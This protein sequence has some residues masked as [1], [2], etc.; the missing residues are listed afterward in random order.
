MLQNY[1]HAIWQHL[2]RHQ[3]YTLLNLAGLTTGLL[4]SLVLSL[5]VYHEQHYDAFHEKGEQIVRLDAHLQSA[6]GYDQH[7][8]RVPFDWINEVETAL[9]EV[10]KLVRFQ[11]YYPRKV[12]VGEQLY[13]ESQAFSTDPYVFEVFSFELLAGNP[14]TALSQPY[15]VVLTAERAQAYFGHLQV[16]GKEIEILNEQS[17]AMERYEVTGVMA[18]LP[19]Q[20]HLPMT[21][22]TSFA[23]AEARSGWAYCYALLGSGTE[24]QALRS[25]LPGF[26]SARNTDEQTT[27]TIGVMPLRAIH[28]ASDLAREI[29]PGGEGA[30]VQF[31]G[32]VALVILLVAG[33][34][35]AQLASARTL[36]RF[37]EVG[38]RRVLGSGSL[39]LMLF[40]WLEALLL[41]A[42]ALVLALGALYFLLPLLNA[43]L[44]LTLSWN[45]P[46]VLGYGLLAMVLIAAV[47]GAYPAW[48]FARKIPATV[49]RGGLISLRL[50]S[51]HKPGLRQALIV[52]QFA[53]SIALVAGALVSQQQF[54]FLL[55]S[56]RGY[57]SEQLLAIRD[58]PFSAKADLTT[59]M[60]ELR[61][62][63]GV[64]EVSAAMAVPSDEIRDSGPVVFYDLPEAEASAMDVQIADRNFVEFMGLELLVGESL[65][66]VPGLERAWPGQLEDMST[67]FEGGERAYL[68]NETGMKLAGFEDPSAILGQTIS[69]QIGSL[70]LGPGPVVG[71]L[72]DYHQESMRN[73]IDPTVVVYDPY[74]FNNL[75]IKVEAAHYKETKAAIT[76][77]WHGFYPEL[78]ADLVFL[79]Q[80]FERLYAQDAQ[81]V[82]LLSLFGGLAVF[83]ALLGVAGLL[84]YLGQR[85]VRDV[86]LRRVLG[87]NL[88]HILVLLGKNLLLVVLLAAVLAAP[89]SWYLLSGWLDSFAYRQAL[90]IWPYLLAGGMVLLL[91]SLSVLWQGLRMLRANPA[92]HLK[93]E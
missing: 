63:P 76:A 15:S 83:V 30:V 55:H 82:Q 14:V 4:A 90:T 51:R 45:A 75:L 66:E 26:V 48:F 41:S 2:R 85:R 10:H 17:G 38:V 72:K 49:L 86:A 27:I 61:R 78:P 43:V 35:F 64:V 8:A 22:L 80:L 13:L 81:Q 33:F 24:A 54:Q 79:D 1:L 3:R 20:T 37:K 52:V 69:W 88:G 21:M 50:S 77:A 23:S 44:G 73:V 46:F 9:P 19:A 34:N 39:Q 84:A 56:D 29:V 74:F 25:K 65:A 11:D 42:G 67:Y 70:K 93:A 36:D 6:T 31:F 62:L 68:I 91:I 18:D 53:V 59:L 16:M 28:L 58:I 60:E 7:F 92:S 87:A 57:E 32:L 89:L 12:R 40:F 47:A 71:V 5:Y